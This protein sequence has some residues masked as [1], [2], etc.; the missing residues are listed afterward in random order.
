MIPSSI[1]LV[2]VIAFTGFS[3]TLLKVG[4]NQS[5]E[6]KFIA[7][8]VNPYILTAYGLYVMATLFTVYALK[9]ISLNQFY[10]ATSMKF[11]LILVLSKLILREKIDQTKLIAVWLIIS[12]VIVFNI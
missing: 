11:V 7:A 3:Q 1:Y 12:G 2:L 5:C 10:T 9:D 4:A 6:K 8:Y